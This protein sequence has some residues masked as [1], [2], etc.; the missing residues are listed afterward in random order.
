MKHFLLVVGLILAGSLIQFYSNAQD[1][2][3]WPDSYFQGFEKPLH[4][5]GFSYHSPLPDVSRSML[6]RADDANAYIEWETGR[7]PR[8]FHQENAKFI[9][10]FGLDA[11]PDK[12]S[13][14]L[15]VNDQFFL[16]FSNPVLSEMSSWE[17]E[18]PEGGKI[19][20]KPVMLD[21]FDD[22]MGFAV[23]TVPTRFLIPGKPQTIRISGE[24]AGKR[25]WYMTFEASVE[26]SV[27]AV[28]E[29]VIVREAD[30]QY[31]IVQLRVI[32][33]GD[34]VSARFGLIETSKRDVTIQPGFNSFQ[35][36]VPD[37]TG[38]SSDTILFQ[39][40]GQNA[41]Y[42]VAKT[43][44]VRPWNIFLVQHTHTDI[45][46]TRPQTEI[47][48]EHLRYIDYA[49]DF[50]DQTDDY[51]PEAQFR[52]TCETTWPVREYLKSRTPAQI[53]RLRKRVGEGRI[54]IAGLFLNSSDLADEASI[55]NSLQPIR[56]IRKHGMQVKASMQSDI[57]GV[58]WCLV[59]Y[60]SQA[61]VPYL[62]M[63]NNTHRAHKP[64]SIPTTFWW[65]SQAGNRLLV[66]RA[67]HYMTG[68]HLGVLSN[69]ETFAK[70]LGAH[71]KGIR[72]AGYPFAAYAIQFCGYHTD[73]APPSRVACDLV[74]RWNQTYVWPKIQLA[75]VSDFM[76]IMASDHGDSL[77]VYRQ[78][79]P[80]W[81]IDG[82][83]SAPI[84]TAF[85]RKAHADNMANKSL[86][87]FSEILG[88]GLN[89]D[90]RDLQ[91]QIDDALAFYDEHTFGAAES[92]SEPL[93]ENSIVQKGEKMAYIWEAVKKISLMEELLM[94][95][96]QDM[97]PRSDDPVIT[98]FN[99]LN[100]YRNGI[101]TLYIDHSIL[102]T[103]K[104]FAILDEGN[105]PIPVQKLSSRDDGTY[106]AMAVSQVPPLG[107]RT[108]RIRVFDQPAIPIPKSDFDG[109]LENKFYRIEMDPEEGR[110][111]RIY[112]KQLRVELLD[113]EAPY[114]MGDLIR[115]SL[116]QNRAQLEQFR[117]DQVDRITWK[118]GV[119]N[120]VT[121]GEI[122]KT[123][124]VS[125][126]F[127]ETAEGSVVCQW[128]LCEA[129]K[130]IQCTFT[131][132]KK[133]ITD[134]EALYVA[135]PFILPG[136]HFKVDIAG[137]VIVP[138]KDQLEG[139][140]SDWIAY[141]N[142][143]ALQNDSLQIVITSPE[144]PMVQL[145]DIN[146]GDFSR[147]AS[148]STSHL[149][150]WVMNNYWTTNFLASE[151][152]TLR[153]N[154]WITSVSDT[155]SLMAVRFGQNSRIPFLTR[156]FPAKA[157][158]DSV[159]IPRSF[160][161]SS[162]KQ[163]QLIAA[164]PASDGS[165]IILNIREANGRQVRFPVR[166]Y[167]VSILDLATATR[168]TEIT[169]VNVLEEL[170]TPVYKA[171]KGEGAKPSTKGIWVELEPYQTKFLKLSF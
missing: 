150:S 149:Y 90:I 36:Q 151:E 100:D 166:D 98:V 49:L 119:S 25:T 30:D 38:T 121:D 110:V 160:L 73:N 130:Q 24:D 67:E 11:N 153:W 136:S 58:P 77:P 159:I 70:N 106:W 78:A 126:E 41:Q 28:Q 167:L 3:R 44:P 9:W 26:E 47:L 143:V 155:S 147:K 85:A 82:F 91:Y 144:I 12:V 53:E 69:M 29:E 34:S 74:R 55:A 59:D 120:K 4:G 39:M 84:E 140:C 125:G 56:T 16:T 93:A 15:Y 66:N 162:L 171:G 13:W 104:Q 17:V 62:N 108:Y 122:W 10:I 51:P 134:P 22:P 45:G 42:I 96:V 165:G 97:F 116:G 65:E 145:G 71:L 81:W 111:T 6:I 109:I 115:E 169:E 83:G 156:V 152:G 138:G 103:N 72:E 23:L 137:G 127:P 27:Q 52:W 86:M 139:S 75:T 158:G 79:W 157:Q 63:A 21:R 92:I 135:F 102:P 168:A 88:T 5:S 54:E 76:E 117:L 61:E 94:G 31:R 146:T 133:G 43:H 18:A 48:P 32:H 19:T 14:N 35:I 164:Y 101:V 142:F 20:F 33:L 60:L 118:P 114:S 124:T 89:D 87:A 141:Q 57:N 95:Q 113:A 46:Y 50:C 170:V 123:I 112:D 37:V 163:V 154:Y 8:D 7:V 129:F 132:T 148:P 40:K 128:R 99:P 80:D 68:N 1:P 105:Q 131:L 2:T 161:G 107:F 64:F